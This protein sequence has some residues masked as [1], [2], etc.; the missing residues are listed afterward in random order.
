MESKR[1][2]YDGMDNDPADYNALQD[3]VRGSMEHVV[4]DGISD[5]RKFAGFET[6]ITGAA[7]ITVQPGRFY[8]GG[9][10]YDRPDPFVKDF[11][12]QLPVATKK[13]VLV[14]IFGSVVSTNNTPRE[15]LINEETGASEPR[16]VSLDERRVCN[17][18]TV[19]GSESPDPL[20][21]IIDAGVLGVCR[22]VL[23]PTGVSSVEML[24]ANKLDS[25]ASVSDRTRSLERFRDTAAPQ[26]ISLGSDLAAL[27]AGV[28]SNTSQEVYGRLL[29]RIAIVEEKG[30]IPADA[31]DSD[32]DFFLDEEES[33]LAFSGFLAKVEEGV[34]FADDAMNETALQIFNALDPSA[35]VVGG[36]M[37]PAYV[38]E[39]RL[40]VGPRQ[41]ETSIS[42]FSYQ[43]HD[44][45][46][47]TMTRLRLRY[48][49][50]YVIS[51]SGTWWDAEYSDYYYR[52]FALPEEVW[53]YARYYRP[54]RIG[55]R[56]SGYWFDTVED[57]YWDKV[58]V[59]TAVPGAQIAETFLNSNDLWLDAI[60]LTFTRLAAT[61][62]AT[63]AICETTDSGTPDLNAVVSTTTLDRANMVLNAETVIPI[64][65]TFLEG[66]KRYAVVVITAADHWLAT[67]QGENFPQGTFFYVLDGAYQQGDATR[68]LC[69]SLY[70]CKFNQSRAVVTMSPLSL[71]GGIAAIDM[72]ADAVTPASSRLTFEIQIGSV[73][74]PLGDV[75]DQVFGGGGNVPPLVPLRAVFTGTPDVMPAVK[76]TGSSVKVSRPRTS[77]AHISTIRT[78]PASST[79]IRVIAR[80]EAFDAV[81]HTATGKIRTGAG[82]TTVVAAS[83]SVDQTLQDG[84]IERTWLFNLGAG[85]TSYRIQLEGTTDSALDTFTIGLRKDYAL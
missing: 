41:S 26:I 73:W 37:L 45:I 79:Q 62:A 27:K 70:A 72:L 80:L 58:T 36:L 52:T 76:L 15:F 9:I 75:G 13:N 21:P 28:S 46:Q 81:H 22:V 33:D 50:Q 53:S 19:G 14:V 25:V 57:T 23:S 20:D 54:N 83:S 24:T 40:A 30:G 56:R 77:F 71:S 63:V 4:S 44:L 84:S 39:L 8:S 3:F 66:G 67:T 38:R 10:V 2:F 78:L 43:T 59:D 85:V 35:K 55:I 49:S 16:T 51:S 6:A 82:Y 69:F 48:G 60:G 11:T 47:K 18:N 32:A 64:Q 65:P 34:R 42:S 1:V 61:G 29:S 17:I 74:L 68:D 12:T 7:E 5:D 31:A